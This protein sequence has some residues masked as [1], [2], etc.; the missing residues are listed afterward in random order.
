MAD[1]SQEK[2]ELLQ[3]A[4]E[5]IESTILRASPSLKESTFR[6]APKKT[7]VVDGVKHEIDLYV[8][9]DQG[10]GYDSVFIFECKNWEKSVGKNEIIVFSEKIKASQA[11]KGFFV[12]KKFGKYARHQAAGDKR[13][14]L[15]IAEELS[16]NI[17]NVVNFHVLGLLTTHT[18]LDIHSPDIDTNNVNPTGGDI[19][20][21][22]AVLNGKTINFDKYIDENVESIK[23][24]FMNKQPTET[25]SD[26]IYEFTIR[27]TYNFAEDEL[28]L[29]GRRIM[30]IDFKITH[31]VAVVHPAITSIFDIKSRGRFINYEEVNIEGIGTI[32]C[33]FTLLA[34]S[35]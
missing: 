24:T 31:K 21:V 10:F 26:G 9:I 22:N 19:G 23:E 20:E 8:E 16:E 2:G 5:A 4:T 14:E 27:D 32:K 30:K 11:Q 18:H 29:D 28:L 12:A 33:G 15:L 1:T 34:P 6:F 7:V 13:I 3:K 35:Q 17:R 25:Y